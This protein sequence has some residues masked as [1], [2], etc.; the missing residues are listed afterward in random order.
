MPKMMKVLVTGATGFIG[1]AVVKAALDQSWQV[2]VALRREC[3]LEEHPRLEKVI[4]GDIGPSTSWENALREVE[5]VIHTAAHVHQPHESLEVAQQ[6]HERINHQ[7]SAKLFEAAVKQGVRKILFLSSI[8]VY[9]N[10][11]ISRQTQVTLTRETPTEPDLPY[12]RSKLA[13]E[14]AL[15]ALCEGTETQPIILRLPM[16]YGPQAK[17][18]FP[19]LV[20]WVKK[21]WPLPLGAFQQK[22]NFLY[23]GNL[24]SAMIA[25]TQAQQKL[26]SIYLISD[27][28]PTSLAD[29]IQKLGT[30][31]DKKALLLPV[32][33]VFFKGLGI[34]LK[35]RGAV[36]RLSN[37]LALDSTPLNQDLNWQPPYTIAAALRET[38]RDERV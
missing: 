36:A 22:R 20:N 30:A 24:V 8:Y 11:V 5:V 12:G 34:L 13:A 4:V 27:G 26:Q 37:A 7:G 15:L 10:D 1:H 6:N 25:L 32:P 38:A 21:G 31:Y 16:V 3:F 28:E 14:K 33:L 2:V 35:K 23:R 19:R 17:G 9:L 29:F 18:N